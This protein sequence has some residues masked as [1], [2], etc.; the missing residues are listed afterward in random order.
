MC[1]RWF[2]ELPPAI[3]ASLQRFGGNNL[4]INLPDS[5]AVLRLEVELRDKNIRRRPNN[6]RGK[7]ERNRTGAGTATASPPTSPTTATAT[8]GVAVR[9]SPPNPNS[10]FIPMEKVSRIL[11]FLS[12][13]LW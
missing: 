6:L 4:N 8:A 12:S 13:H 7:G 9:Q 10:F 1:Y 5:N 3:A 2:V 11:V